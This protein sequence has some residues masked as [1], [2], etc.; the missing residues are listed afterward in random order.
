MTALSPGS[1]E[2][3]FYEDRTTTL[4]YA[5]YNMLL[6]VFI[7][8]LIIYLNLRY[9]IGISLISISL[10]FLVAQVTLGGLEMHYLDTSDLVQLR[11][12][13]RF[14]QWLMHVYALT[15]I[16]FMIWAAIVMAQKVE[17]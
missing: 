2:R 5:S 6:N 14:H 11:R 3:R 9:I 15:L 4:T 17:T 1:N 10:V 16:P 8:A 13:Y 7:L 12:A